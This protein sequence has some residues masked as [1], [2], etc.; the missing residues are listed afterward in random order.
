MGMPMEIPMDRTLI[1]ARLLLL[2]GVHTLPM[3]QFLHPRMVVEIATAVMVGAFMARLRFPKTLSK[4]KNW[5]LLWRYQNSNRSWHDSSAVQLLLQ[6]WWL[7]TWLMT[8][9][10]SCVVP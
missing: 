4:L 7:L 8:Q 10:M 6:L 2:A 1:V 9:M 3:A 5:P